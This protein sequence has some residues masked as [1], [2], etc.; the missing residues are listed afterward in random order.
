MITVG[1]KRA[2][3]IIVTL[4]RILVDER[5]AFNSD[6]L[7]TLVVSYIKDTT[8]GRRVL[9]ESSGDFDF[10]TVR[11]VNGRIVTTFR[12]GTYVERTARDVYGRT[13]VCPNT[14]V[15][16]R[17]GTAVVVTADNVYGG[18]IALYVDS[19]SS[20]S[21]LNFGNGYI[22]VEVGVAAGKGK[23]LGGIDV[24]LNSLYF[25]VEDA[26]FA[27]ILV[28]CR[29]GKFDYYVYVGN[30]RAYLKGIPRG[31]GG[32]PLYSVPLRVSLRPARSPS[33]CVPV[34]TVRYLTGTVLSFL[35]AIVNATLSIGTILLSS[36]VLVSLLKF[37]V[38]GKHF[39]ICFV[40]CYG[41]GEFDFAGFNRNIGFRFAGEECERRA[42]DYAYAKSL[43]A[44]AP[45]RKLFLFFIFLFSFSQFKLCEFITMI[46]VRIDP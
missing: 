42:R 31:N 6:L 1:Y 8:C 21:L 39:R 7:Y 37:T 5:A 2:F 14:N 15:A 33:S 25:V 44:T 3:K 11:N 28:A 30:V 13:E 12:I 41:C 29:A 43:V 32:S 27:L 36:S 9:E 34:I 20:S 40:R 22:A 18:V 24:A 35:T 19:D 45:T 46:T 17:A 16:G 4:G 38:P 10:G 23:T 26:G